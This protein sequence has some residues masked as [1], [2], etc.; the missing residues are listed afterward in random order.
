MNTVNNKWV[1]FGIILPLIV[2]LLAMNIVYA[3]FTASSK[4]LASDGHNTSSIKIG[5]S[6]GTTL[7]GTEISS[8]SG[9]ITNL[10]PGDTITLA[11]AVENNG[12]SDL[13]FI[14]NFKLTM[15]VNN[16]VIVMASSN[17]TFNGNTIVALDGE[18]YTDAT[19]LAVSGSKNFTLNYT[20]DVNYDNTYQGATI[21]YNLSGYAIQTVGNTAT[22]AATYL[23]EHFAS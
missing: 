15:T 4:T 17:Y 13:Y 14:I 3:L 20:L 8:A 7:N 23:I 2:F 9:T 22:S 10:L 12:A 19:S 5:F 6:S 18:N 16:N 21:G 11:G 1:L